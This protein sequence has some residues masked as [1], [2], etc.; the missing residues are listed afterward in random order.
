M[1]KIL[2]LVLAMVVCAVSLASC[3]GNEASQAPSRDVSGSRPVT[4]LTEPEDINP[5]QPEKIVVNEDFY[6]NSDIIYLQQAIF[7]AYKSANNISNVDSTLDYYIESLSYDAESKTAVV[8][9]PCV[10][11]G[12]GPQLMTLTFTKGEN[13]NQWEKKKPEYKDTTNN[14]NLVPKDDVFYRNHYKSVQNVAFKFF[15]AFFLADINTAKGLIDSL[16]N[17]CLEYFNSQASTLQTMSGYAVEIVEYEVD[18]SGKSGSA[19]VDVWHDPDS[20]PG[21]EGIEYMVLNVGFK[22]FTKANG[23]IEMQYFVSNY[24]FDT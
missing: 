2:I 13:A 8:Q 4:E 21:N 10:E 23:E 6:K 22:E 9:I 14:T 19:T 16:D 7:E 1:K 17:P 18:E 5:D 11:Q 20:T 24:D 12:G 15:R 3:A